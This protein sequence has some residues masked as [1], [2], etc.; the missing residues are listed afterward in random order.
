MYD[1]LMLLE[2]L[3]QTLE[4]AR[5]VIKHNRG[6]PPIIYARGQTLYKVVFW[7]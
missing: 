3:T 7:V 5:K 2:V 4:A 1:K 6:H